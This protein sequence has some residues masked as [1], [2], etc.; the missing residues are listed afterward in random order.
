MS[1]EVV[2]H[3]ACP[4]DCYDT[5]GLRVHSDGQ[6][7]TRITGDADHPITRG[8]LCMK[9]NKYL[10]RL[11][12]PERV[13]YPLRRTG[14]KGSGTFERV[15]WDEALAEIAARLRGILTEHGGEAVLP[16]S[17]AG[18]MGTISTHALDARFFQEIGASQLDRTICTASGNAALR[19]VFGTAVGPD[20]EAISQAKFIL[21]WGANPMATNI[22]QVPMTDAAR[23]SGAKVWTIDPLRTDSAARYDRHLQLRPQS[24]LELALGLGRQL[25]ASGR[26]DRE[27]V[28]ERAQGFV[29]YR[30]AVE[31]WTIAR[32]AEATGLEPAAIDYLAEQLSSVRPLLLRLGYGLQRQRRSAA[33]VWAISM[34]SLLTGSWR[35]AGGGLLLSNGDAFPLR[36]LVSG[37]AFSRTVNM[38][39]LGEA[40]LDLRDPPLKALVVYNAN[41]AATAPDQS[42]VLQGLAREDLLTVV[43]EQMLTDT[44]K[45]ADFILPAAMSMETWDLYTSYWHRY[46]QLNRPGAPP[47]GEAVSNP[48]FF[49]RLARAMDLH[50]PQLQDDDLSLIR[51]ALDTDDP[52]MAGITLEALLEHPVQKLRIPLDSRPF[53]DTPVMTPDGK[54]RMTPPPGCATDIQEESARLGQRAFHLLTPSARETI[55]SSFGNVA[56]VRR[57]HPAPELLMAEEDMR[58]LGVRQGEIVRVRNERGFVDMAVVRS[59]VPAPGTVVSYAVRW[60]HEA[61]GR[62]INQLTSANLADFGGGA[63]FYDVRVDLERGP[64]A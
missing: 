27:M 28:L 49:R 32:T 23:K 36:P 24:D 56:S 10:D 30:E 4:H 25:L 37:E 61:G 44:A 45:W 51:Q 14:P 17:F 53:V 34:L 48:E 13:L 5:C 8:F 19:W 39:Q 40:L 57:G 31:P 42:R 55:K 47:P 7:I 54:F 18:N 16:Y 6:R 64:Q 1:T 63:T 15:S 43:H 20:P 38:V 29:A 52:V 3:G 50:A 22:H 59:E 9:V 21:L 2:V 33:V 11:Y 26:F 12:H 60:N 62:N 46:V 58:Q 35:D 41:P